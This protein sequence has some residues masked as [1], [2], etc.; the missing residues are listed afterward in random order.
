[1]AHASD[2]VQSYPWFKFYWFFFLGIVRYDSEFETKEFETNLSQGYIRNNGKHGVF[3]RAR[4]ANGVWWTSILEADNSCGF[5]G[6]LRTIP[7]QEKPVL[8]FC[9]IYGFLG[10]KRR[11]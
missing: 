2:G 6:N 8:T 1:M 10:I 11:R 9:A 3:R 7:S 4:E 5:S